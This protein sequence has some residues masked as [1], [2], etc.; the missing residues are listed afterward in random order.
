VYLDAQY[1]YLEFHKGDSNLYQ[2]FPRQQG[3]EQIV[4]K[5]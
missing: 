4:T 1:I 2:V 3:K 5:G